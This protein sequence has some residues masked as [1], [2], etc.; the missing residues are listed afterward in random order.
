MSVGGGF[1]GAADGLGELGGAGC[2]LAAAA[3]AAE[4]RGHFGG[5]HALDQGRDAFEVAVAATGEADI[6]EASVL[7][8]EVYAGR[9]CARCL[10]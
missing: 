4:K 2:G 3:D 1:E 5:F 7:D 10:V 9:A 8:V 6:G